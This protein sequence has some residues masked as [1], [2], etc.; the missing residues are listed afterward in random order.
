VTTILLIRHGVFDGIGDA[1]SGSLPGASLSDAGIAQSRRLARRLTAGSVAAVYSS[2]QRRAWQ[3]ARILGDA[4]ALS[5]VVDSG[6][7]EV[8]FGE[9]TDR[10][11]SALSRDATFRAF[12]SQRA[13]TRIPDGVSMLEVQARA[14]DTLLTLSA[15]HPNDTIVAVSHAD[16]IRAVLASLLGCGLD[17]VLR[18]SIDPA[19]LTE[20]RLGPQSPL[21]VCVND[22]AHLTGAAPEVVQRASAKVG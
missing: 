14:T 9:W 8:E 21:I 6:L 10:P 16:V 5:P 7:R 19:S 4:L 3:T 22:T 2:P 20:I 12:N 18:L 13:L 17:T 1:L 11:V 15:R